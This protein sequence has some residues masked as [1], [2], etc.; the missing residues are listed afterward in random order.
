MT[1]LILSALAL[2]GLLAPA[3]LA[4]TAQTPAPVPIVIPAPEAAP[5]QMT[6]RPETA[7]PARKTGCARDRHVMS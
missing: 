6:P 1:R 3:A 7:T 5:A 2:G 4:Q